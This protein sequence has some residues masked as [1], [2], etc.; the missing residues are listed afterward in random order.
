[1]LRIPIKRHIIHSVKNDRIC[2]TLMKRG[3][4]FN[5]SMKIIWPKFISELKSITV[6]F[7]PLKL[8]LFGFE[9]GLF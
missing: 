3:G 1:M 4:L 7:L 9:L 8:G 6:I 2:V 5:V